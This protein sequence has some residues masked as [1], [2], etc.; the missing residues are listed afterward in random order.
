MPVGSQM[1]PSSTLDEI[2][3]NHRD[4]EDG[5]RVVLRPGGSTG[6]DGECGTLWPDH[7]SSG[8]Q[9]Q[10]HPGQARGRPAASM[11][12]GGEL[13]KSK[14]ETSP[15]QSLSR[16]NQF[17]GADE[18]SLSL[19]CKANSLWVTSCLSFWKPYAALKLFPKVD[20]R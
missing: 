17:S 19:F 7:V 5:D 3:H 1:V 13:L 18:A 9:G 10:G 2:S 8:A 6:G 4:D 12:L 14:T 11:T 16:Q 15:E 20:R